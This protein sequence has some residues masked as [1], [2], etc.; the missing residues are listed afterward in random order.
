MRSFCQKH[1]HALRMAALFLCTLAAFGAVKVF[2]LPKL[3]SKT[4]TVKFNTVTDAATA[5]LHSGESLT[6]TFAASSALERVAVLPDASKAPGGGTLTFFVLD[7]TG[8]VLA[9][10]SA[11][12]TDVQDGGYVSAALDRRVQCREGRTYTLAVRA[13]LAQADETVRF[14]KS[15]APA[16]ADWTLHEGAALSDG[17]TVLRSGSAAAGT[18]TFVAQ[19]AHAGRFAVVFTVALAVLCGG[20][21]CGLYA[22]IFMAKLPPHRV[23]LAAVLL[24]GAL[25]MTVLPPYSAPDEQFHINQSFNS[26][27]RVLGA[28]PENIDWGYNYKRP[29]DHD[30]V[31]EDLNTS[32]FTYRALAEHF[33]ETSPD[34]ATAVYERAGEDVGGYQLPYALPT[35]GVLLGR[36]CHLGF[37]PTLY[38][39]RWL[40][41]LFYAFVTA[42]AVKLAPFGKSVFALC[43]LL[44]MSLHVAASF[45]RD[46]FTNAAAFFLT[47][48][49]LYLAYG[50]PCA[51][52]NGLVK[53]AVLAADRQKTLRPEPAPAAEP[54]SAG[55]RQS[56]ENAS[57]GAAPLSAAE[58]PAAASAAGIAAVPENAAARPAAAS[59]AANAAAPAKTSLPA[60]ANTAAPAK[61]SQPAAANAAAPVKSPLPAPQKQLRTRRLGTRACQLFLKQTPDGVR[62]TPLGA[63]VCAVTCILFAPAKAAYVPLAALVLLVPARRFGARRRALCY[64]LAVLGASA[65]HYL[66]VNLATVRNAAV[67]AAAAAQTAGTAAQT[68]VNPDT[69]TF[70]LSYILHNFRAFCA[71]LTNEVVE[72]GERLLQTLIGGNLGYYNTPVSWAWVCAFCVLLVLALAVDDGSAAPLRTPR[73]I[74]LSLLAILGCAGL[75]VLGCVLWTPTYYT[76]IYGMQGRYFL[77]MLPLALLLCRSA[78][79]TAQHDVR[80]T[81]LMSAGVCNV[82]VLLNAYLVIAQR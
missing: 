15:A 32:I 61:T 52:P 74:G 17:G 21:L 59:F 40:N 11:Q 65:A 50:V 68:P 47:A 12:L 5:P 22:A 23:Y 3:S 63:A 53:P 64:K 72:H 41:L 69:I 30:A 37:V 67:P 27:A 82:C 45:S 44:P 39:A 78:R 8:T 1:K 70:T 18:L 66:L 48:L 35:L 71:L 51:V 75:V 28:L 16:A 7:E 43:A 9:Q 26:A 79:I 46:C 81:L 80:R 4:L 77:P 13:Q 2:A 25:Y 54:I 29:S 58:T 34:A 60:A 73:G 10:G 76:S 56:A 55:A 6:Q 62:I 36:V 20:V 57:A 38:L 33:F 31:I 42:A 14:A 49:C 24:L 19:A